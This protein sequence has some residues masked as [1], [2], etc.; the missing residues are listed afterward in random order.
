MPLSHAQRKAAFNAGLTEL[1][2]RLSEGLPAL[3]DMARELGTIRVTVGGKALD[4]P[5]ASETI[6]RLIDQA[7]KISRVPDVTVEFIG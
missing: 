7:R 3:N 5:V 1:P 4:F 2:T 6:E